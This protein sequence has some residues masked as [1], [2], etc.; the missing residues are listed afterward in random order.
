MAGMKTPR[1]QGRPTGRRTMSYRPA[2]GNY[3]HEKGPPI[4]TDLQEGTLAHREYYT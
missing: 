1:G 4:R 2:G 3:G